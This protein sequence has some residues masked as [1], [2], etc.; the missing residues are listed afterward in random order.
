M[1]CQIVWPVDEFS[2]GVVSEV[3]IPIHRH[4]IVSLAT[5]SRA[6]LQ[7]LLNVLPAVLECGLLIMQS[8]LKLCDIFL[9]RSRFG[10]ESF[11]ESIDWHGHEHLADSFIDWIV[12]GQGIELAGGQLIESGFSLLSADL[13]LSLRDLLL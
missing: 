6:T 9:Q 13:S 10:I 12:L 5:S 7:D 11:V 3:C 2:Q 1:L 4:I 8:L